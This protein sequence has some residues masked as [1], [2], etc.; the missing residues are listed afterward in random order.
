MNMACR[1]NRRLTSSGSVCWGT[2]RDFV[3]QPCGPAAAGLLPFSP[4]VRRPRESFFLWS[5]GY[6]QAWQ[7]IGGYVWV[8]HPVRAC[9]LGCGK[10]MLPL[11]PRRMSHRG[12]LP[13]TPRVQTLLS[14]AVSG[15]REKRAQD[16]ERRTNY[17]KGR[18]VKTDWKPY[19]YITWY[20]SVME[21]R[22]LRV[23]LRTAL[24][25]GC[26]FWVSEVGFSGK[27]LAWTER[28]GSR[29]RKDIRRELS[30]DDERSLRKRSGASGELSAPS[31]S[32]RVVCARHTPT[33][34]LPSPSIMEDSS[35]DLPERRE[36]R[37]KTT[38]VCVCVL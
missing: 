16:D 6:V 4:R 34:A 24:G 15:F 10:S 23:S 18:G 28:S 21:F 2:Q 33:T 22:A 38:T 19:R 11:P 3:K 35:V 26:S 17:L 7:P 13:N 27:E 25:F 36:R 5:Q 32:S 37:L 30:E 14:A 20:T 31:D 29:L 12:S 9:V 8:S 1:N